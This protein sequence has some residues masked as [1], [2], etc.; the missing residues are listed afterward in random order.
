MALYDF[1][2][3]KYLLICTS[4]IIFIQC[5]PKTPLPILG[6]TEIVEGKEIFHEIPDFSFINQKGLTIDNNALKDNIYVADFFFTH[7]PS[8]CPK[9][10]KQMLRIYDRYLDDP[11]LKLVSYTIDP[12]R[13]TVERLL[14]YA[15]GIEVNHDKWY[16]LTGNKDSLM[17]LANEYFVV[18]YEDPSVPGGFDHS[19][20]ILL[21]DK[22]RHI[23]SFCEGTD[24]DSVTKFFNDIDQLLDEIKH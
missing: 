16:F 7:C 9:V 12:K 10:T 13:D 11:N 17:D 21:V 15:D 4:C 2:M 5:K 24:P 19:G 22:D 23:R 14:A 6:R 8:I 3:R 1:R 18:A 20:K